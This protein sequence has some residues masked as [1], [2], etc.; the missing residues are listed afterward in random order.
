MHNQVQIDNQIGMV[1]DMTSH[2]IICNFAN[3]IED[4]NIRKLAVQQRDNVIKNH[5][6]QI[7]NIKN[8]LNSIKDMLT[9]L[10]QR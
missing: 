4:Y 1:R 9:A 5:E 8:D 6:E 3:K 10:M 7:N 2:A